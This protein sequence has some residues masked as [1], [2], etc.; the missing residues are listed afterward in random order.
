MG[1]R[2]TW[3]RLRPAP[4]TNEEASFSMHGNLVDQASNQAIEFLLARLDQR[5]WSLTAA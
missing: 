2:L 1:R 4:A 5:D 3:P